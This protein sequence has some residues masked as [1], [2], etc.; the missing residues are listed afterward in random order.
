MDSFAQDKTK[1]GHSPNDQRFHH[2]CMLGEFS[3]V[4][5][6]CSTHNANQET[7]KDNEKEAEECQENIH[8]SDEILATQGNKSVVQDHSDTIVEQ[9][10]SKDQEIQIFV[11][12]DFI[13]NGQ[14]GNRINSRYQGTETSCI[15]FYQNSIY[16]F[17]Y[18]NLT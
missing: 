5:R 16:K 6:K 8:S 17:F 15:P 1:V 10:F 12:T 18:V 14:D 13:K 9:G 2:S 4:G 3:E 7:P 11:D